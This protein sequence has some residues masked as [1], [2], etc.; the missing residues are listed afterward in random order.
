L[1]RVIRWGA[2]S[3]HRKPWAELFRDAGVSEP[4]SQNEAGRFSAALEMVRLAP[5]ASNRQPWRCLKE[6]GA[7]HFFLQRFPGY[8]AVSPIDLQRVDMG[9]VMAH[10]DLAMEAAGIEGAWQVLDP[11]HGGA[12]VLLRPESWQKAE[13]LVSWVERKPREAAAGMHDQ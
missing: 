13:Y 12:P 11:A 6:G 4:L 1:D 9:I 8:Q 7:F 3:K 5:S 10:F 2:G